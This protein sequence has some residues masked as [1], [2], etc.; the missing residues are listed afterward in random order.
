M[1]VI[2]SL[3][4]GFCGE[5]IPNVEKMKYLGMPIDRRLTLRDHITAKRQQLLQLRNQGS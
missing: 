2:L 5:T 3:Q 4:R 1:R